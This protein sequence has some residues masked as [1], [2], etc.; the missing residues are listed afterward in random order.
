MPMPLPT[1]ITYLSQ[2]GMSLA[3]ADADCTV[4]ARDAVSRSMI[5]SDAA[6]PSA[7][8]KALSAWVASVTVPESCW[9]LAS[10]VRPTGSDVLGSLIGSDQVKLPRAPWA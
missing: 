5:T 3:T 7:R 9:L 8:L 4:M 2:G 1:M 10:Q 6:S